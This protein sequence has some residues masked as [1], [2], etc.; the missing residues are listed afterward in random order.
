MLTMDAL[1]R[2]TGACAPL[3]CRHEHVHVIS[4]HLGNQHRRHS[5]QP[6]C[7]CCTHAFTKTLLTWTGW[8]TKGKE[9]RTFTDEHKFCRSSK[10]CRTLNE[11]VYGG[12]S[13]ASISEGKIYQERFKR[14]WC[15]Q[16][17]SL[18]F[19]ERTVRSTWRNTN[20]RLFVPNPSNY[21]NL[22]HICIEAV[23]V[24]IDKKNVFPY[25][26]S[27]WPWLDS[28]EVY[29]SL[30]QHWVP[31]ISPESRQRGAWFSQNNTASRNRQDNHPMDDY[32]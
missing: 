26:A 6:R 31:E 2:K 8:R 19:G 24:H 1:L 10:T 13:T 27:R 29:R 17:S 11:W 9:P 3:A 7:W 15:L 16:A 22:F 28:C 20:T 25:F 18:Q 5:W 21:T 23:A 4:E 32:M 14:V 30:L 12:K